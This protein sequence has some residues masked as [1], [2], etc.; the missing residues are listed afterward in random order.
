MMRIGK[1][2]N[3]V[4]GKCYEGKHAKKFQ[5]PKSKF[6]TKEKF[7]TKYELRIMK[8]GIAVSFSHDLATI[9]LRR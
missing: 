9:W 8:E 1:Y 7:Q 5:V 4:L 6:Q 3:N 2:Y